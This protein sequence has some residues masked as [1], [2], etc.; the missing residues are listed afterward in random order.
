[1]LPSQSAREWVT[2][3]E[4]CD[5]STKWYGL[6]VSA[7]V[8]YV[9]AY[10]SYSCIC[11]GV[12]FYTGQQSAGWVAHAASVNGC[13]NVNT[14]YCGDVHMDVPLHFSM[15]SHHGLISLLCCDFPWV[16]SQLPSPP[17]DAATFTY[18]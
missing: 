15:L 10:L 3:G 13:W 7:S 14:C 11:A 8:L 6:I 2:L 12:C 4:L 9:S 16:L 1:M 17:G 18:L 5:C